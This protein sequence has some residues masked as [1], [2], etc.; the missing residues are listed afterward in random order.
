MDDLSP[1]DWLRLGQLWAQ[2]SSAPASDL[3]GPMTRLF[4]ELARSIGASQGHVVFA[5]RVDGVDPGTDP[6]RGWRPI[7]VV[8]YGEA[9]S[10]LMEVGREWSEQEVNHLADPFT[11]RVSEQAGQVRC[12]RRVDLVD[13]EQWNGSPGGRLLGRIG[14]VD[15]LV[16]SR[17]VQPD[18]ELHLSFH[19]LEGSFSIRHRSLV[20]ASLEGL[21]A[22]CQHFVRSLGFLD[23]NRKLSP[24]EREA[25]SGLLAGLSEKAIASSMGV[26][27]GTAHQYIVGIYRAFNVNARSELMS[28]WLGPI[29]APPLFPTDP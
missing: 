27:P 13:D 4:G 7:H 16:G 23:A 21:A 10:P 18:L 6:L 20:R 25:L 24:R 14:V 22:H 9:I 17:P 5:R 26:T 1:E 11:Q 12:Y 29:Y 2:L 8:P 19:R 28:L 3:D 15:M